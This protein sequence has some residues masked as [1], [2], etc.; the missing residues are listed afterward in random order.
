MC[1]H[2]PSASSLPTRFLLPF[3]RFLS[4]LFMTGGGEEIKEESSLG[5]S[6]LPHLLCCVRGK[7]SEGHSRALHGTPTALLLLLPQ[8]RVQSSAFSP[9]WVMVTPWM[10]DRDLCSPPLNILRLLSLMCSCCHVFGMQRKPERV[11]TS[12]LRFGCC[13][14]LCPQDLGILWGLPD[15]AA[16]Q[17]KHPWQGRGAPQVM[18]SSSHLLPKKAIHRLPSTLRGSGGESSA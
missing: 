18:L 16:S 10:G 5:F 15:G 2:L 13:S 4:I 7:A 8:P 14:A 1:P 12:A 11:G 9:H 17:T 3:H 6:I